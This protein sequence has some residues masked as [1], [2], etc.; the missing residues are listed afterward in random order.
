M[1]LFTIDFTQYEY[2]ITKGVY[3][4]APNIEI[5]GDCLITPRTYEVGAIGVDSG[6]LN[7]HGFNIKGP[8]PGIFT[9]F[10]KMGMCTGV[11]VYGVNKLNI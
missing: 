11:N 5:T 1:T 8:S 7:L 10:I 9:T 2:F 3:S 6:G 4:N